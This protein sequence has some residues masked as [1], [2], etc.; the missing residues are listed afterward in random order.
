MTIRWFLAHGKNEDKEVDP[1]ETWQEIVIL[2]QFEAW[3]GAPVEITFAHA[4]PEFDPDDIE[5]AAMSLYYKALEQASKKS[6]IWTRAEHSIR[7]Y[8]LDLAGG[9]LGDLTE[10]RK[11]KR[12]TREA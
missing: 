8:Y 7:R 11:E 2:K 9:V 5:V 6:P 3:D 1:P 10:H 12:A 4:D